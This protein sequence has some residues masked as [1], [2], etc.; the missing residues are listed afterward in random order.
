MEALPGR[1]Q[2]SR[3]R[4]PWTAVAHALC[5]A[6]ATTPDPTR[7]VAPFA[8]VRSSPTPTTVVTA[9]AFAELT[10]ALAALDPIV[11]APPRRARGHARRDPGRAGRGPSPLRRLRL[12]P[13][14]R[15]ARRD[16]ADVAASRAP[17]ASAE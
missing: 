10:D 6:S 3:T 8:P 12:A 16:F 15:P 1:E 4:W 5:S 7:F 11:A 17:P 2:D 13:P 14:P 9:L